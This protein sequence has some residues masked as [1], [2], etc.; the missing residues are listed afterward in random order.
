MKRCF[1]LMLSLLVMLSMTSLLFAQK[2]M[3]GGIETKIALESSME[4][5]LKQVLTEITG[6]EKIIVIIKLQLVS[7]KDE[8]SEADKAG[9]AT[10][11]FCPAC[12]SKKLSLR[13]RLVMP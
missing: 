10:I 6:T 11:L 4:T 7:E 3:K 8:V 1:S 5:R 13:S 9:K 2:E 12:R